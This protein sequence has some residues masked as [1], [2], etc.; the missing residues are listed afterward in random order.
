[1]SANRGAKIVINWLEKSRAHRIIWLMEELNLTYEIRPFKR[2]PGSGLAPPE[3]KEIHPLGKSPL[4]SIQPAGTDGNEQPVMVL[5]ESGPIIEYFLE[6]FG[7]SDGDGEERKLVPKKWVEGKKGQVGGE[8]EA[9]MRYRY[10]MHYA[11]GSLMGPILVQLVMNALQNV[12]FFIKPITGL[13]GNKVSSEY[14]AKEFRTHFT[15][16]EDQLASAPEDGPFLCGK[17]LSAADV[18]MSIPVLIALSL[19]IIAREEYP[20]VTAYAEKLQ[21]TEGFRRAAERV[22][23]M[24]GKPFALL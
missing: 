7:G 20:R 4:V 9:W 6:H 18:Q 21:S 2:L 19:S 1:M 17:D 12:P 8:T 13:I 14:L 22:E 15:F 24:E 16:L 11:E 10:Y 5:A 3:L 23:K